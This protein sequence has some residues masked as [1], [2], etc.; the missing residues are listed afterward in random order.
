MSAMPLRDPTPPDADTGALLDTLVARMEAQGFRVKVCSRFEEA[1]TD[2]RRTI[3]D[4]GWRTVALPKALPSLADG[5]A[6]TT[7]PAEAEFGL[8]VAE[9]AV[10]AAGSVVVRQHAGQGRALSL[11]PPATGFLVP[12]QGVVADLVQLF[13]R[14]D[15]EGETLP[16]AITLI[17]GPSK[18]ADIELELCVGVHGP[19]EVYVWLY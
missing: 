2:V 4:R 10:T 3:Q 1:L 5:I 17:A 19:K 12:R 7:P 6:G 8:N 11:L 14:F 15:A 16:A 18:T 13:A 9:G